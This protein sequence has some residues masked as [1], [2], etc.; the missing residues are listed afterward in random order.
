MR[1]SKIYIDRFGCYRQ[2][3]T[4][5]LKQPVT[6]FFGPNEA[7]KS[8]LH[9]FIR[10]ILYGYNQRGDHPYQPVE[11][12]ELGG[13][14]EVERD[15]RQVRIGRY[16]PPKK[17][18]LLIE[19][20]GQREDDTFLSHLLGHLPYNLFQTIFSFSHQELSQLNV[21]SQEELQGYLYAAAMGGGAINLLQMEKALAKKS[22][23]WFKPKGTKPRINQLLASLKTTEAEIGS[24]KE[25]MDHY[26]RLQQEKELIEEELDR[27]RKKRLHLEK[28]LN[29]LQLLKQHIALIKEK[30]H[31]KE[32]LAHLGPFP[33]LAYQREINRLKQREPLIKAKVEEVVR[34]SEQLRQA[35]W[36]I[37]R[38]LQALG[39]PWQ[40][41]SYLAA[42][43]TLDMKDRL[44]RAANQLQKV[45]ADFERVTTEL[46][47]QKRR[48]EALKV[49]W[50][51][52]KGDWQKLHSVPPPQLERRQSY[53]P[54]LVAAGLILLLI[55]PAA[56]GSTSSW[57]W[58][59]NTSLAVFL[60]AVWFYVERNHK[61]TRER[62]V[63][64][65]QEWQQAT[66]AQDRYL[67]DLQRDLE[68]LQ[69]TIC[70]MEAHKEQLHVQLKQ[71][72]ANWQ[73]ALAELGWPHFSPQLLP[74]F[75]S[76]IND[77]NRGLE[78]QK[79]LKDELKVRTEE[80]RLWQGE[81][82]QLATQLGWENR[83]EP[84]AQDEAALVLD[85][86]VEELQKEE[87]ETQL[88]EQLLSRLKEVEVR[89]KELAQALGWTGAQGEIG[90]F[91]ED[92]DQLHQK[93]E[94]L[95][96]ELQSIQH[97]IELKATELGRLE[98]KLSQLK[99]E[100]RLTEQVQAFA[101]KK[102]E[103][104]RLARRY[105]VF[106]LA[107][108]LLNQT[109]K[110]YEEKRQPEVLKE[111]GAYFSAMTKGRYTGLIAPLGEN[112][113]YVKDH[114]DR[115]WQL[116]QLSQGTREQL[117][118]ALRFAFV[119]VFEQQVR[120]PLF[121]D[122]PLVNCDEIRL[123]GVFRALA[124]MSGSHQVFLFTCHP[125]IL[126]AAEDVLGDKLQVIPLAEAKALP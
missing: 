37:E 68:S 5:E 67:N 1:I 64:W 92:E 3:V 16:T 115:R 10:F 85:K 87:K 109:R 84:F 40:K 25:E 43:L 66:R 52:E 104:D 4:E 95:Q 45:E 101:E 119:K 108:H 105:S 83:E 103:L 82:A 117:Y 13:Y 60:G 55:I 76:R 58:L 121:L 120:L 70:E 36:E 116:T 56:V 44:W 110:I 51:Q 6:I 100:E 9:A 123:K 97:H 65:E 86:L 31:L 23:E 53:L 111:A 96:L 28:E 90:A 88:K 29:A 38:Q 102:T 18:R 12:G 41:N 62:L 98:P 69:R 57:L 91:K 73:T 17:G 50:E 126:K 99:T 125:H 35:E 77:L 15:G 114:A 21:L 8:T 78:K 34:L 89:E 107:S 7:G 81:V 122:D 20:D 27:L 26:S 24:L 112:T 61:R 75:L 14:L 2:Y 49:Q 22:Q 71:A 80:I 33:Y 11:G 74:E 32:K 94:A 39:S 118:L 42:R 113:L 59:V 93:E 72:Q 19:V 54:W 79:Q 106:V 63:K 46:D 30:E 47:A 124:Q 48:E